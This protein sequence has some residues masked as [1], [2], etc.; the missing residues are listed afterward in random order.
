MTKGIKIFLQLQLKAIYAIMLS[1]VLGFGM[2]LGLNSLYFRYFT[3]RVQAS[4]NS[5]P[6]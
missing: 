2:S 3:W 4:Q 5:S 1:A 6:V